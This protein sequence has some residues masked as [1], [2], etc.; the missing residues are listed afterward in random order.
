MLSDDSVTPAG[1]AAKSMAFAVSGD[2]ASLDGTLSNLEVGIGL[3]L[4]DVA[5]GYSRPA[6]D[7]MTGCAKRVVF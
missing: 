5:R 7:H 2:S 1:I 3:F 6:Q 4:A